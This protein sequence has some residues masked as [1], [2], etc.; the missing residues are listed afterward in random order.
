MP[1]ACSGLYRLFQ[2]LPPL[3]H[4]REVAASRARGCR[5]G[6]H[7]SSSFSFAAFPH[8]R[9]KSSPLSPSP[10]SCRETPGVLAV[11]RIVFDSAPRASSIERF[12]S[13]CERSTGEMACPVRDPASEQLNDYKKKIKVRRDLVIPGS[14]YRAVYS[15]AQL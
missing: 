12:Y 14:T 2:T 11:N 13:S 4:R 1:R 15:G 10:A 3:V 8:G 5:G 7:P 6:S 9:D